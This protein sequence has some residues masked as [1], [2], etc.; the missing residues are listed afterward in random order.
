MVKDRETRLVGLVP[1][2]LK[3]RAEQ[4]KADGEE[5]KKDG[6]KKEKEKKETY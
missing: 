3:F 1:Q 5:V 2:I 6:E 4:A